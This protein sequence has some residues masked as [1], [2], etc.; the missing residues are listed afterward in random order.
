MDRSSYETVV[1]VW[2]KER[3]RNME[4][5]DLLR[6]TIMGNLRHGRLRTA[7]TLTQQMEKL[8]NERDLLRHPP[9]ER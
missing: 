2:E 4:R 5:I 9:K 7:V 3:L 1:K 8:L 6:T